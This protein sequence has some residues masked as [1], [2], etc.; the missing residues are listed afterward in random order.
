MG[1]LTHGHTAGFHYFCDLCSGEVESGPLD[2]L[3]SEGR[4]VRTVGECAASRPG[5]RRVSGSMLR[6]ESRARATPRAPTQ[7]GVTGE[8]I[9]RP[10]TYRRGY[11][12][13]TRSRRLGV[14]I[15]PGWWNWQTRRTQNPLLYTSVRVQVPPRAPRDGS[16]QK[17]CL[18]PRGRRLGWLRSDLRGGT[19]VGRHAG[20]RLLRTGAPVRRGATRDGGHRRRWVRWSL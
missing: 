3:R 6:A 1:C 9:E 16:G 14:I 8:G 2:T 13:P 12:A 11:A 20:R 10:T 15:R 7:D 17:G 18:R 5:P 4:A 19:C